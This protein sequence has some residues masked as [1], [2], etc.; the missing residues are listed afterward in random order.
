MIGRLTW[1]QHHL[2]IISTVQ[3]DMTK[4][5]PLLRRLDMRNAHHL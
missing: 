1:L 3:P 4:E 5:Q 2:I